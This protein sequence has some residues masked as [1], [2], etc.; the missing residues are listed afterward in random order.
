M[1]HIRLPMR[2]IHKHRPFLLRWMTWHNQITHL[3][4]MNRLK[5]AEK[6]VRCHITQDLENLVKLIK[7]QNREPELESSTV[8]NCTHNLYCLKKEKKATVLHTSTTYLERIRIGFHFLTL[9]QWL[10]CQK[11][12][13]NASDGPRIWWQH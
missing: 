8:I 7:L 3:K 2:Q 13:K 10:Q 6:R 9:K 4:H 12:S 1:L 11:L 5:M